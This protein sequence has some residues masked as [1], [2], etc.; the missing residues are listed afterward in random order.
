MRLALLVMLAGGCDALFHI[1]AVTVRDAAPVDAPGP[2]AA[3]PDAE[4]TLGMRYVFVTSTTYTGSE[5]GGLAI[6]DAHCTARAIVAQLPG[7][8]R[9]WLSTSTVAARDH[10]RN[11]TGGP[12][13]LVTNSTVVASDWSQLVGGNLQ[14]SIQ[15]DDT[16]SPVTTGCNVWTNTRA[17][18]SILYT[19]PLQYCADWQ[20]HSSSLTMTGLG[21]T[22]G[23]AGTWTDNPAC[24][25][26]CS[27][28]LHLY[29][30]E[31]A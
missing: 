15:I 29:C 17:D 1:D 8:Y 12:F 4:A 10:I 13:E 5:V 14:S 31:D 18:G 27:T 11:H 24:M 28:P 2:D 6:A 21:E 20:S 22:T 7:A 16:G 19:A 25:A 30:I 23:A 9:A 26:P 3:P